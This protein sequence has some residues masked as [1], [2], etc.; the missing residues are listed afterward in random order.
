VKAIVHNGPRDLVYTDIPDAELSGPDGAIVRAEICGICGSDLHSRAG[1]HG[2]NGAS[3]GKGLALP[4]CQAQFLAGPGADA[5]LVK[6]PKSVSYE[7]IVMTDNAPT[8]WLAARRAR[9]TPGDSVAVI[10]LGPVGHMAVMAAEAKGAGASSSS[11]GLT[12]V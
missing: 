4:G 3:W 10:G 7:A 5:N 6:L 8:A 12:S 2:R 11:P 1:H 9:I